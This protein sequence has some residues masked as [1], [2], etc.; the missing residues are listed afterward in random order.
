MLLTYIVIR[1][2][3][4]TKLPLSYHGVIASAVF[5]VA[6]LGRRGHTQVVIKFQSTSGKNSPA[7][8]REMSPLRNCAFSILLTKG[9]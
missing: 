9:L 4:M 5:G 7:Y 1:E 2:L 3:S 8:S 6:Y